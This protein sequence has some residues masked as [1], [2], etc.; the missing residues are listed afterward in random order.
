MVGGS[1]TCRVQYR[2]VHNTSGQTCSVLT[3][4]GQGSAVGGHHSGP[5]L[6]SLA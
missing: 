1:N 5:E 2:T 4:A 3:V 6:G